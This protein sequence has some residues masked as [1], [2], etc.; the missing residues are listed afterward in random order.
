M[1]RLVLENRTEIGTLKALGYSGARIVSHYL[2]YS[3]SAS[4]LGSLVGISFAFKLF[5]SLIMNAYRS[6]YAIPEH[7]TPFNM[8]LAVQASL[9]AIL[10]TTVAAVAATIG[11]L[12]EVPASLMSSV[13]L[14]RAAIP[15]CRFA[16]ASR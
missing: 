11:E 5:P 7:V 1:T 2:I 12:R 3:L 16:S 4:L 9:L 10:F 13:R 15:Y 6:L 8:E 14:L